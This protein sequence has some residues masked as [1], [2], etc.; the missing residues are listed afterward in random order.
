M[1]HIQ[2]EDE[3]IEHQSHSGLQIQG[4]KHNVYLRLTGT[5]QHLRFQD[6]SLNKQVDK[7]LKKV[8]Q[9]CKWDPPNEGFQREKL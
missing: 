1:E 5:V 2:Q 9:I 3:R 6:G 8:L 4:N 7:R